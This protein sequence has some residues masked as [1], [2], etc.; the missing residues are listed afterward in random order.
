[1]SELANYPAFYLTIEHRP[2]LN[3]ELLELSS[4]I[5]TDIFDNFMLQYIADL[6]QFNIHKEFPEAILSKRLL[7]DSSLYAISLKDIGTYQIDPVPNRFLS[8]LQI[9]NGF[10]RKYWTYRLGNDGIVRRKDSGDLYEKSK[11][12]KNLMRRMGGF[13]LSKVNGPQEPA[14]LNS[15]IEEKMGLNNQ[16]VHPKELEGLKAFIE[17]AIIID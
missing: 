11:Q 17:N 4:T 6:K 3:P 9:M 12:E 2:P 1:M 10:G 5:L 7:F 14:K 15:E 13:L 16:P 8:V